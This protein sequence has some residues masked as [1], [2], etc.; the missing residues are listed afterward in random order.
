MVTRCAVV[1][2]PVAHSL[3]PA[4]HRAAHAS[5]GLTDW[6]Y[7]AID[8]EPGGLAGFIAGLD[9]TWRG[10]SVTMP[11]KVDLAG[12]A[13]GDPTVDLLGVAN[14][15]VRHDSTA[16]VANTDVTGFCLALGRGGLDGP[17][18][19]T[20][21]GAGA[22]ARSVL[23]GAARLGAHSAVVVSRSFERAGR[24][25]ELTRRLGLATRWQAFGTPL[26]GTD[27]LVSTVPAGALAGLHP[28]DLAETGAVFDV[29]Y[30]PWPT[31]LV[32]VGRRAGLPTLDGLDLLA[33]QADDQV[34]LMT[35][36]RADP[37]VLQRAARE[38]VS[39][40]PSSVRD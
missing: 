21:L 20:V 12:L 16:R 26:A 35:G 34:W 28:G 11:H 40:A 39:A 33:A 9:D 31:P 23:A 15:W 29:V 8:V 10:L 4:I 18:A 24:T 13:P 30:D 7:E 36:Q 5:L 32:V 37:Q 1:G 25:L 17:R 3:S 27:L 2:H 14:T 38:T 19:V 22:T 6:S